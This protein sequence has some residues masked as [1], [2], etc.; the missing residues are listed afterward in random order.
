MTLELDVTQ[1]TGAYEEALYLLRVAYDRLR[2]SEGDE[3]G[4]A[5]EEYLAAVEQARRVGTILRDMRQ[6]GHAS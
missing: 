4:P 3:L 1:V 6:G 5:R 2:A